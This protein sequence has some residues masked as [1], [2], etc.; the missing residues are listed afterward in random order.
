VRGIVRQIDDVGRITLPKN[1][2]DQ[3]GMNTKD[4]VEIILC[5]DHIIIK[6]KLQKENSNNEN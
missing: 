4:P 6:S 2:R 1:F 5:D 3:L